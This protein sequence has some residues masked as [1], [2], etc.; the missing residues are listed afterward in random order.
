MQTTLN[1]VLWKVWKRLAQFWQ[2]HLPIPTQ[3]QDT[4]RETWKGL[5]KII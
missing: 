2:I 3:N 5:N 4:Y 1:D